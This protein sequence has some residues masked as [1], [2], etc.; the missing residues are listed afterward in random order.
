MS[1]V[2][3]KKQN[4][5]LSYLSATA[6]QL[7]IAAEDAE[8][9]LDEVLETF[10]MAVN[11]MEALEGA[12]EETGEVDQEVLLEATKGLRKMLRTSVVSLQFQDRLIQRLG[13]AARELRQLVADHSVGEVALPAEK[14]QIPKS[15]SSLYTQTQMARIISAAGD[16]DVFRDNPVP[17]PSDDGEEDDI[18]LF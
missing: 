5:L 18:T 2:K 9:G 15:V 14:L 16:R 3:G 12:L 13:L 10:E 6:E 1:E 8:I 11:N 7:D 17:T 4:P